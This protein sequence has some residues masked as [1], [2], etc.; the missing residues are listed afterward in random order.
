MVDAEE[1]SGLGERAACRHLDQA[2]GGG[3][4]EQ[5][6]APAVVA[7]VLVIPVVLQVLGD[8]I[9]SEGDL[10][11]GASPSRWASRSR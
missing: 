5:P 6:G 1:G 7:E 3:A 10:R 9:G 11:G 8:M 4:A 2:E